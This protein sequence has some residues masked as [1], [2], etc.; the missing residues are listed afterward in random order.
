MQLEEMTF[1]MTDAQLTKHLK[2]HILSQPASGNI[3]IPLSLET[4]VN[5]CLHYSWIQLADLILPNTDMVLAF[6]DSVPV[7]FYLICTVTT[8][9]KEVQLP[10]L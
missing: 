10:I 3:A 4:R 7:R 2:H 9:V 1:S 6:S 5:I 8:Y